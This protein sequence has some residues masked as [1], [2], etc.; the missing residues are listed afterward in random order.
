MTAMRIDLRRSPEKVRLPLGFSFSAVAAGIKVSGRPDLALVEASGGAFAAA[1]FTKNRV[2]AAPVEIG[3]A[4]LL[5][6]GGRVRAI[7]VNSGN[8]NCATGRVGIHACERVCRA[9]GKLLSAPA[10]EIFPSST[11]IIGVRLPA[12]KI[13]ARLPDLITA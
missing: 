11:G 4:S 2:V 8:A 12:D 6:T 13:L 3:R 9:A 7:I 10:A 5:A 1:L